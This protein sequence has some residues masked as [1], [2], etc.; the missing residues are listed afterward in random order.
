[1]TQLSAYV[2]NDIAPRALEFGY[3]FFVPSSSESIL[4]DAFNRKLNR[5]V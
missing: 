1:M 2:S 5:A 3:Q 4:E